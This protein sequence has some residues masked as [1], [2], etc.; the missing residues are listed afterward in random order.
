MKYL[1]INSVYGIRSTGKIIST[2]CHELTAAGNECIAAYG[3]EAIDDGIK[4]VQ[5]GTKKDYLIHAGEA[6]IFDNQGLA[7]KKAT[8]EFIEKMEQYKPDVVWL[9]NI[10]GYYINYELLF[11]WIKRHPEMEVRWTL[12]DCWAFTGH[13]THFTIAKC[14]KW[15]THCRDCIQKKEY[16]TSFLLDASKAN[17]DKKRKAF[18]GVQH[19]VIIT[20]SEWLAGLVKESFLKEYPVQVINNTINEEIFKPTQSNF[21]KEYGLEEKHIVLGVAVGWESTKGFPDMLLLRKK[22]DE[23]YV[24]VLVGLTKDQFKLLPEGV[25]GIERTKNQKQLAEIYTAADV[26]VNPT[27]QDNYPTVNLE[28]RACGT[29]V[30]TYNVGG[31]PES[32]GYEHVV[33]END[34][35][36][37]AMEITNILRKEKA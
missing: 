30:V 27:H 17:Y 33:Q 8:K 21:R 2:L 29:P 4:T 9:H 34:I 36:A 7:S 5:I 26:F 24:I 20:P 13:C 11:G 37:L 22:L 23:S 19:M 10:H 16:P 15:K 12:H 31:S 25:M 14:E 6:R 3:R 1:F 35:D 32:A 18:T 28:A